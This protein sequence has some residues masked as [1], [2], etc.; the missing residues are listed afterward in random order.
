MDMAA[1]RPIRQGN[2]DRVNYDTRY[3]V[4]QGVWDY[5][6]HD[7]ERTV[8]VR[9]QAAPIAG[10][11]QPTFDAF[12]S[13]DVTFAHRLHVEEAALGGVALLAHHDVDA[14]SSAL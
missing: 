11:E 8:D 10:T 1:M 2:P 4:A 12:A 9:I 13:I 6:S 5:F 3:P 14:T 7:V